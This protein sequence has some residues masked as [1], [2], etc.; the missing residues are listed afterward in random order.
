MPAP[1][2]GVILLGMGRQARIRKHTRKGRSPWYTIVVNGEEKHLGTNYKAACQKAGDLLEGRTPN[3]APITVLG[4]VA[5]WVNATGEPE[6][7]CRHLVRWGGRTLLAD[8]HDL[9]GYAEHLEQLDGL[10]GRKF[11]PA[12][13]RDYIRHARTC[14]RWGVKQGYLTE[15]PPMP[16]H[17]PKRSRQ[18][19]DIDPAVLVAAL[20]RIK[21]AGPLLRFIAATACRPSEACNLDWTNVDMRHGTAVLSA[22]KTLHHGHTR[23][24]Y[25]SP[26]ALAALASVPTKAGTVFLNRHGKPYSAIGLRSILRRKGIPGAYCLRHT[27]AQAWLDDGV[28]F[29]VVAGLLGHSDLRTVQ[30]YGQVRNPRLMKAAKGLR[31]PAD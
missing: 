7:K 13:I 3:A 29:G 16:E 17:L 20:R 23:T 18:P 26:A 6:W 4:L 15:I 12:S 19:R 24:V 14:L 28:D 8:L 1:R 10:K 21:F 25:L 9:A 22:H 2:L 27:A 31:S 30:I 11:M 5:A